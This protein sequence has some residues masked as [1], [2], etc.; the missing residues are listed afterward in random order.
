MIFVPGSCF[1][2]WSTE[3][4]LLLDFQGKWKLG[5]F[6]M[7]IE[8][9]SWLVFY[10]LVINVFGMYQRCYLLYIIDKAIIFVKARFE[11]LSINCFSSLDKRPSLV[12]MVKL[13]VNFWTR[14]KRTFGCIKQGLSNCLSIVLAHLTKGHLLFKWWRPPSMYLNQIHISEI[15]NIVNFWTRKRNLWSLIFGNKVN[16][17][18][19]NLQIFF[20]RQW[21]IKFSFALS[22]ARLWHLYW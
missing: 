17:S 7:F 11:K 20:S 14:W 5:S 18:L 8:L 6:N 22:I 3:F 16:A 19:Y 21:K 4:C 2:C 10:L 1:K 15:D 9:Q 12:C 13:M